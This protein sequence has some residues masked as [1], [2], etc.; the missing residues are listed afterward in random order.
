MI[1]SHRNK[2]AYFRTPKTGSTTQDFIL[3]MCGAFDDRD[4]MTE[5]PLGRFPEVNICVNNDLSIENG[6]HMTPQK[7]FDLG[8]MT[9]EQF[10][11][12]DCYAFIREP[13]R[14]HLSACTHAIGRHAMPKMISRYVEADIKQMEL[15]PKARKRLGLLTI[16]QAEYFYVNGEIVVEACDTTHLERDLRRIIK[17]AGGI[18]FPCIPS[19]NARAA[20]RL[21]VEERRNV[22]EESDIERFEKVYAEDIRLYNSIDNWPPEPNSD[23]VAK[24]RSEYFGAAA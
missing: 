3:R 9:M 12:Y 24:G 8:L 15:H 6:P 17:R 14:R 10:R 22:W 11:E 7:A 23:W 19:M 16:P 2:F 20:V 21:D 1:I 5:V 13:K 4:I 18:D